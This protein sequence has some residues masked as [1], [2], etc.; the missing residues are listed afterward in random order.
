MKKS[1]CM[2][3]HF[4]CFRMSN[5]PSEGVYFASWGCNYSSSGD[6]LDLANV[7]CKC[8]LLCFVQPDCAYAPGS[9]SFSGTGIQF[10][11]DFGVV[12]SAVDKLRSKGTLVYLSIGGG[13][14]QN[15]SGR[16]VANCVA[17]AKDLH[18]DG[19]D[20]DWEKTFADRQEA[21]NV[22]TEFSAQTWQ[23]KLKLSAAVWST[24]AYDNNG[25]TYAGLWKDVLGK[26]GQMLDMI[27]IMSYGKLKMFYSHVLLWSTTEDFLAY[28]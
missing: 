18:C 16:K 25:D 28:Y 12:R 4:N 15:W 17:L 22:I 27:N 9:Q 14:Y 13:S 5:G 20:I 24:G 7:D 3:I 19:I 6:G 2:P 11:S 8:V 21:I 1:N 23:N 10:S 26:T